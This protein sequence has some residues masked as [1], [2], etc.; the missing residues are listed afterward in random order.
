MA[1]N[2]GWLTDFKDIKFA[3]KTLFSQ[4]Y[5]DNPTTG[6]ITDLNSYFTTLSQ[7][8]DTSLATINNLNLRV[9]LGSDSS[10][11]LK[12]VN[13]NIGVDGILL[14]KHGGTGL[15]TLPQYD[16]M[17]GDGTN[18]V[19]FITH[20]TTDTNG[21]KFL[22]NNPD[23]A[24]SYKTLGVNYTAGKDV[25]ATYNIQIGGKD[26]GANFSLPIATTTQSGVVIV[27]EQSFAGNKT[28]TNNIS[29]TGTTT[30]TGLLTA[31]SGID[32]YDQTIKNVAGMTS[33]D[34]ERFYFVDKSDNTV[35]YVDSAGVSAINFISKKN[36]GT[37][38]YDMNVEFAA[39]NNRISTN[40]TDIKGSV[41]YV[42]LSKQ[43]TSTEFQDSALGVSGATAN[44]IF[45]GSSTG[46]ISFLQTSTNP[47]YF[48]MGQSSGVPQFSTFTITSSS[49]TT[50]D[51]IQIRYGANAST[52]ADNII[53][54]CDLP[55]ATENYAGVINCQD[56][57][58]AGIKTFNEKIAGNIDTADAFSSVRT[59]ELTGD[60]TGTASSNGASG[61]TISTTV[62]NNSHSHTWSNISDRTTCTINTSGTITGSAVYGAVWN[63]YAEYRMQVETVKP[64][65]CVVSN[66]SGQVSKTTRRYQACDGIVSDTFG[67]AIGETDKCKTPLA[68]AGRVLAYCEGDRYNYQ[69][70]D[71]VC[72]GPDGKVC[73]M[74][75]E[76]IQL[77]PD[78]IVGI[79]SEIP[80]YETWGTGD[81]KVNGRI[82]IKIK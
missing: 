2:A 47:K 74:T 4:V 13:N 46:G 68:V 51:G 80:E 45:Y 67:F 43:S 7:K 66:N 1:I 11:Q 50:T 69:A 78:R 31:Q 33:T 5:V 34:A 14:V 30:L 37:V 38:V 52:T 16:L 21:V 9:T 58:F 15:D 42:D 55:Y 82:W 61:W 79:V 22:V 26:T 27:G 44:A 56:Q 17:Y 60:V 81:V 62:G 48:L 24:P 36:D 20:D 70:G 77:W 53:T 32:V 6:K 3:P 64:G 65:Y 25:G 18:A 40:H 10:V 29:V 59:I 12:S 8:Y 73:K 54:Y 71:T 63:D 23:A 19:K 76:E 28:F 39:V 49:S 41:L 57:T 75:R 35:A 72:A